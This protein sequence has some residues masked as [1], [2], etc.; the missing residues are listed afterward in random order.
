MAE[1]I[2]ITL[3]NGRVAVTDKGEELEV[4]LPSWMPTDECYGNEDLLV[5][6]CEEAGILHAILQS[7]IKHELINI[8]A[9][10]R[11]TGKEQLFI[12]SEAEARSTGYVPEVH[13][14]PNTGGKKALTT[15]EMIAELAKNYSSAEIQEM[16]AGQLA[17]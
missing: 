10:I 9:V 15:A 11:P 8:R 7:G 6:H 14:R 3:A 1:S 4:N 16:L 5:S 13:T 12:H 2:Y 17:E